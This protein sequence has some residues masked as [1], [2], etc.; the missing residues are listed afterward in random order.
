MPWWARFG[1][2]LLQFEEVPLTHRR[3]R[4]AL[5]AAAL[6]LALT[7]GCSPA[8]APGDA[9]A[10]SSP[11]GGVSP[12]AELAPLY[13]AALGGARR[14]GHEIVPDEGLARVAEA[15]VRRMGEDPSHRQ[16]A[17]PLI[18]E[19][20]WREGIVEPV[21]ESSSLR[22]SGPTP[23]DGLASLAAE[24]TR[25]APLNR[26]GLA[27]G[28]MGDGTEAIVMVLSRRRLSFD[29]PVA[30]RLGV[31]GALRLS[32]RLVDAARGPRLMVTRPDGSTDAKALGPGPAF[33]GEVALP[34]AGVYQVE[35]VAE[36]ERGPSV[37]VNFPVYVGVEPPPLPASR[38]RAAGAPESE[39]EAEASLVALTNEARKAAG[40]RPLE[41]LPA[42]AD[43]ARKHSVDMAE[44]HFIAHNSPTTGAPSDRV[45]RAGIGA[46]YVLENLGAAANAREVHEGLMG[47]PGHRA[48][49]L[50]ANATHI[51]VG[52]VRD[53]SAGGGLIV[54]ENFVAIAAPIDVASAP[55]RVLEA[56]NRARAARRL[57]ALPA[58]AALSALA[59]RAAARFF[60]GRPKAEEVTS[61]LNAEF[62]REAKGFRRA[63]VLAS[64][65]SRLDDAVD[66]S[67]DAPFDPTVSAVGVGVAQGSR[68]DVGTN[69]LFVVLLFG[70]GG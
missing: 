58:D 16:P 55:P 7:G 52:V 49:I 35:L 3:Y 21:P 13:D 64:V 68:P 30:R 61:R 39:A 54:T 45:R 23:V 29:A 32:G 48:N 8:R 40:R 15:V 56:I 28:P 62:A 63:R 26:V 60:Q 38:G 6:A 37:L 18:Q 31:G 9:G 67:D 11:S 10:Y 34:T 53:P 4:S 19:L 57:P 65:V 2:E 24:A 59:R 43:V 17:G 22:F 1:R 27:R 46:M 41:P 69:A 14:S 51:G 25:G 42:L 66:P 20:A 50:D 44:H 47:S 36:D 5:W 12:A 70:K 33:A